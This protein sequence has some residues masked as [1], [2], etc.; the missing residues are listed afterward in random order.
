MANTA[1]DLL[2]IPDKRAAKLAGISMSQLRHWERVGLIVPSIRNAISP[3]NVVRLY[4]FT[5]M[6][7]LLVAATLRTQ[8]GMPLQR[9]RKVVRHLRTRGYE[10]P[11]RELKFTSVNN[12]IFFQHPDGTW[13]GDLKPYQTV[14]ATV[15][16]LEPLR[17]RIAASTERDPATVGQIA[18]VRGVHASKPVIAGTRIRVST[19][20]AFLDAGY[21]TQG[22]LEEYPSLT[23]A[24]VEAARGFAAAS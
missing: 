6:L 11:L 5:D 20:R 1:E 16:N 8:N 3:R 14:I 21:D 10:S 22:I 15:L 24:D 17:E 23:A 4:K 13:E 9:I 12:E 7:E 18:K 19:I 2:A